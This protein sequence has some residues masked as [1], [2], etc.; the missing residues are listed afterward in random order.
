MNEA[1]TINTK[2]IDNIK[3]NKLLN[4]FDS[5][6]IGDKLKVISREKVIY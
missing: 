2:R 3:L 1:T 4:D 6:I 5:V